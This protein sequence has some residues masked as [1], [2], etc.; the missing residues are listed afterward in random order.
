VP[1]VPEVAAVFDLDRTLLRGASGPLINEALRELG[2]R[3]SELP[4]ESLLYQAYNLFGENPLG[5]TLA[6]TAAYAVR[7][8]SVDRL[9]AAG[10]RAAE[11]LASNVAS[12]APALLDEHRNAG[13]VVVL[14]T[15][16]PYDLVEP[17]AAR[18]GIDEVIATRYA[19]KDGAYTG[20]LDGGFVWGPGKLSAVRRWAETRGVDLAES[21]AYSDSLN[22]LP[23]LAAVGH[24]RA[25]NPDMPL[26]LAATIARWPVLHLDVPPGVPTLGGH[27]IFDVGKYFVR[28]ELFPY[29]RFDLEGMESIPETGPFLLVSNHRSYFDVAALALVI[30]KRGRPVRFLGKKELFDAPVIGHMARALGGMS[31]ERA[32]A[33]ADSLDAA[34][35]VLEAGEGLAIL[36]QGTIPRG[37]AFFDPK[38]KGKT[39]AARLAARTRAPVVPI[40]LWNT[41]AVW[42]RSRRLPRLTNLLDP[43]KVTVRIGSPVSNLRLG[44]SDAVA[45][46]ERIMAAITKLLP[47][48]ARLRHEPTGEELA[49][50]YPKGRMGEERAVGLAPAT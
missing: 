44:P 37:A 14:A 47:A 48:E 41:E 8:W 28:P 7:G 31:V 13:H 39:G 16:T 49:R 21:Y 2:L 19:W 35:R 33:A 15:T 36:P 45:D 1:E 42:P 24:P 22:D 11:L 18:L 34:E 3:S 9:R 6:R 5:M 25:V 23:L 10:R 29:A 30:A 32:G 20:R 4:G 27:E 12:Y 46:T 43:P 38:L 17:L 26:H 40:G 50:T